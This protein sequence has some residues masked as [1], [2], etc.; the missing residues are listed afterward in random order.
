MENR[1]IF[2]WDND[3]DTWY[4]VDNME[5]KDFAQWIK[6]NSFYKLKESEV[7]NQWEKNNK[8]FDLDDCKVSFIDD[9]TETEE[10]ADIFLN[11]NYID[12]KEGEEEYND[13]IKKYIND[14]KECYCQTEKEV[15]YFEE[16]CN[17]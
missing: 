11:Y 4:S 2:N 3:P 13:F 15:Q 8:Y 17:K 1:F 6:D 10:I 14:I 5:N 9:D 7:M 16:I 12:L